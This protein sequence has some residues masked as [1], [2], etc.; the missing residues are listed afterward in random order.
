M[1]EQQQQQ[2]KEKQEG[3]KQAKQICEELKKKIIGKQING[4]CMKCRTNKIFVIQEITEHNTKGTSRY[5]G[6]CPDCKS[7][8]S[9]I[10][11]IAEKAEEKG[12][13]VVQK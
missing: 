11:C 9:S 13:F 6:I 10:N 2:Q 5:I 4:S 8:I 7:K 3:E 1:S 12:I